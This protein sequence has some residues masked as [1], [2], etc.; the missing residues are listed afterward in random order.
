MFYSYWLLSY[1]RCNFGIILT[2]NMNFWTLKRGSKIPAPT[3]SGIGPWLGIITEEVWYV[4]L[5]GPEGLQQ[6]SDVTGRISTVCC[7]WFW[8]GSAVLRQVHKLS[9]EALDCVTGN[10]LYFILHQAKVAT[11]VQCFWAGDLQV[12]VLCASAGENE[13]ILPQTPVKDPSKVDG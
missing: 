12:S 6:L 3:P 2:V 11:T 7:V 4:L 13:P 1:Q 5:G 8:Q 9:T 10:W